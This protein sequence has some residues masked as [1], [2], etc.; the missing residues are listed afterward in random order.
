MNPALKEK[1]NGGK[2]IHTDL[3]FCFVSNVVGGK[4]LA[5]H[6]FW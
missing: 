6:L 2:E 3:S 4:W 5:I 1:K